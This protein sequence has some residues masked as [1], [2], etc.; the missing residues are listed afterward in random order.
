LKKMNDAT[1]NDYF[2]A[3]NKQI[4]EMEIFFGVK[5]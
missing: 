5:T 1:K 3:K 2:L 4:F